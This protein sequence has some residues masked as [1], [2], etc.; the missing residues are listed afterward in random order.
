MAE[1]AA[2]TGSFVLSLDTELSWG[3]FDTSGIEV[4]EDAY[5]KTPQII[6]NMCD[7][8]DEYEIPATWALV[9]HLVDDCDNHDDLVSPN[10]D[11]VDWFEAVPCTTNINKELW[12]APGLLER[13][14]STDISHEIGLHGYSHMILGASGCT[15]DAASA[16]IKKALEVAKKKWY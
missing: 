10:Y 11:W 1:S 8:F 4:Y 6:D 5:R 9:M 3:C 15:R 2:T 16:E 13:I 7:L 12:F 14:R